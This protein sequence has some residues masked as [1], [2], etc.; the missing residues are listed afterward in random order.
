M[1]GVGSERRS[2]FISASDRAA[3]WSMLPPRTLRSRGKGI[4]VV[5]RAAMPKQQ[6][7]AWLKE[8]GGVA[9]GKEAPTCYVRDNIMMAGAER[10]KSSVQVSHE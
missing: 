10:Y 5:L 7:R 1:C 2:A 8:A 9:C 3:D 4:Q 6:Q